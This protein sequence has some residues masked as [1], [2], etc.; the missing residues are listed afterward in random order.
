MCET[1]AVKIH[2]PEGF[3]VNTMGE[4]RLIK[5]VHLPFPLL[6]KIVGLQ[7]ISSFFLLRLD[8]PAFRK[9][10]LTPQQ[11]AGKSPQQQFSQKICFVEF[12]HISTTLGRKVLLNQS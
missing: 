10:S 7:Q 4:S 12:Q 3:A 8:F 6:G 11:P 2:L 5:A 9:A 1:W